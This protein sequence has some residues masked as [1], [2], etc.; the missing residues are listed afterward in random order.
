MCK[1]SNFIVYYAVKSFIAIGERL[2]ALV[3]CKKIDK[4]SV[5]LPNFFYPWS[6]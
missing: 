3:L 5:T 2:E 6:I 4:K 1:N